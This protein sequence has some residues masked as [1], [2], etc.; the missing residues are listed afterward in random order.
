MYQVLR[1]YLENAAY[2]MDDARERINYAVS[3]GVITAAQAEELLTFAETHASGGTV[4]EK[5]RT[6]EE[7]M[8]D[9]EAALVELAG[10]I[11]EI[12]G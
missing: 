5:V 2:T 7:R 3:S 8:D 11:A 12:A 9:V 1:N 4:G 10:I 6:L